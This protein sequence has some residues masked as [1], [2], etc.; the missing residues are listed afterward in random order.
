MLINLNIKNYALI[1]DLRLEFSQGL[2]ILSGETGA[3]KSIIIESLGLVLGGRFSSSSIRKGAERAFITAEL[4]FTENASAKKFLASIG[5]DGAASENIILRREMD[6][7]GKSR[8]FINDFPVTIDTLNNF[9]EFLIDIHGQHEHQTLFKSAL[10]RELLDSAAGN[11]ALLAETAGIHKDYKEIKT[12]LDSGAISEAEKN[13]LIDLYS[14]QLDEIEKAKLRPNEEEELQQALPQLKNADKLLNLCEEARQLLYGIEGSV[15]ERLAKAERLIASINTISSSLPETAENLKK[16]Y[17]IAEEASNELEDFKSKL[18]SDPEELNKQL[19]REDLIGRLKKK[20]G[21]TIT[22]ILQYRDKTDAELKAL[23]QSDQNRLELEKRLEKSLSGLN[24]AYS[25]LSASRK[26]AASK[27]SKNIQEELSMLGMKKTRFEI[28]VNK[29][30]EAGPHGSDFVE[31]MFSSNPGEDMKPLKSIASGGEI[32]R[33]MLA[34]KTALAKADKI[35]VMVFDEVDAGIGGPMG[36]VVGKK[37]SELSQHR[38]ILCITHLP[39]IAA[40]AQ[41]HFIIEKR[42]KNNSTSTFAR[43]LA[44]EEHAEEVARMLSGEKVTESAR[45]H[46][47]ELIQAS[48]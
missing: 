47:L 9:G 6:I 23:T 26:K 16:A 2:N 41:K 39:Q 42:V 44:N 7:S 43:P 31:F 1:D 4:A 37:L 11:D 14:F 28:S 19:E 48:V 46:A 35:P 27:L 30:D 17:Y 15:T 38:Q 36:Q 5:L 20:Y 3:G 10:Q 32:S 33:T 18:N 13:K 12:L 34:I 40:F 22:E 8:A 25:K 45:K 24:A 29:T 21:K